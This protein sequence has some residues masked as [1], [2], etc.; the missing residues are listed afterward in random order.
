MTVTEP[1]VPS[2]AVA[3]YDV[4]D[5]LGSL[6]PTGDPLVCAALL[7]AVSTVKGWRCGR[8][9]RSTPTPAT[10]TPHAE[11]GR[12]SAAALVQPAVDCT[13]TLAHETSG[14]PAAR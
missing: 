11:V 6:G 4:L 12:R 1:A 5:R 10:P 7:R 3:L 2:T 13:S 8:S 9:R 14:R